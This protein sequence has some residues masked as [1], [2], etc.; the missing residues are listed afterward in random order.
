MSANLTVDSI[1]TS[2]ISILCEAFDEFVPIRRSSLKK[3]KKRN[4]RRKIQRAFSRKASMWRLCKSQPS[5]S[6]LKGR[7]RLAQA[8]CRRLLRENELQLEKKVLES[9]NTGTFYKYV[10]KKLSCSSGIGSLIDNNGNT[11][12]NNESKASLLNQYFASVCIQDNG[13]HNIT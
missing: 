13:K 9:G 11:V 10:N 5:N 1:W 8:N 3:P 12:V 7:Y 6:E 2:F 4:Y